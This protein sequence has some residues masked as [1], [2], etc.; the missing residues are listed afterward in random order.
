MKITFGFYIVV[1][2]NISEFWTFSSDP[3]Q[4]LITDEVNMRL[5][6]ENAQKFQWKWSYNFFYSYLKVQTGSGFSD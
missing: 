5:F 4:F 6:A 1:G 3:A 2:K